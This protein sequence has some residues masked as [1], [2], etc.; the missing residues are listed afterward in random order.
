M[1]QS[2]VLNICLPLDFR[3]LTI[4]SVN[5]RTEKSTPEREKERKKEREKL[6]LLMYESLGE[7]LC[8]RLSN[9]L[10]ERLGR[11]KKPSKTANKKNM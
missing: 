9:S 4:K 5:Q 3:L 8:G 1:V 6:L 10:G 2:K 11:S 7:W